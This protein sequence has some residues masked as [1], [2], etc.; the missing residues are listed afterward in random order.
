MKPLDIDF[1]KK[2]QKF[3]QKNQNT[4]TKQ[5]VI[6]LIVKAMKFLINNETS[7]IDLKHLQGSLSD[8]YRIRKGK[9]RILFHYV[10]NQILIE[11]IVDDINFRGGIY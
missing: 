9:V 5:E 8:F 11:T 3:L 7:N 2:S 4:I 1:S 6:D 10:E